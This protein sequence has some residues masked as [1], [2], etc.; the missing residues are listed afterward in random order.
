MTLATTIRYN[1]PVEP[2]EVS[3]GRLAGIYVYPIKSLDA[4]AVTSARL[5]PSG[6][7]EGDRSFAIFDA[8]GKYVNGKRHALVHHLRSDFDLARR[9]LRLSTGQGSAGGMWHV[10]QQRAELEAWLSDYFKFPVTFKEDPAAGFPDD[11]EAP[12]P[13]VISTATLEEVASWFP[14]T[15]TEQMRARFRSNVEIGGVPP[16]WEDRLFGPKPERVAFQVGEVVFHGNNPCRRCVVPPRD[17]LTGEGYPDFT[18][19][20]MARREATLPDWAERSRFD[21][22]YRLAINT[23][24][25]PGAAGRQIHLG[26]EIRVIGPCQ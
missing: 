13:T 11:P 8:A 15:T 17:H 2:T 5:L 26:D 20:F 24:L 21:H 18:K 3:V 7:L 25:A 14:G 9:M 4:V 16:F 10:D 23:L 19:T 1:R 12:G 22:F 6:G